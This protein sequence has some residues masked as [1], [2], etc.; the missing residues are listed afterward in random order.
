MIKDVN[1]DNPIFMR[2]GVLFI[3]KNGAINTNDA[4]LTNII[5]KYSNVYI[6]NP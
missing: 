4:T 5:R 6:E 2:F 1:T 3:P